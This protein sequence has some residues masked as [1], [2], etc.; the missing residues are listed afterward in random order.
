[1]RVAAILTECGVDAAVEKRIELARGFVD[2]DVWAHDPSST[3]PQTYVIEC[4][5]WSKAVPKAVVHAFRCVVADS[6]ANWGAIVSSDGF[7]RGAYE[8]ARYSNVRLLT[9]HEFQSL[10]ANAWFARCFCRE[11]H[12]K[13]DALIEYAEPINSRIFRKAELLSKPQHDEFKR[14][15]DVHFELASFCMLIS[16][17]ALGSF[18]AGLIGGLSGMPRLPLRATLQNPGSEVTSTLPDR[19][20]DATSYRGL[21][22]AVLEHAEIAIQSFDHVFGERA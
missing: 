11:I 10:F 8:A 18:Q 5:R 21:L 16:G 15:R 13:C 19:V 1:M 4:K 17:T 2:I 12:E 22:T 14:L 9:W 7:Q 6:G 3:P 20:L